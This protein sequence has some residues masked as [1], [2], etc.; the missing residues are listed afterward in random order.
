[1]HTALDINK[2]I[3]K[4]LRGLVWKQVEKI[5]LPKRWEKRL[6]HSMMLKIYKGEYTLERYR[7]RYC[8]RPKMFECEQ[9]FRRFSESKTISELFEQCSK[10]CLILKAIVDQWTEKKIT[11]ESNLHQQINFQEKI[12]DNL[13]FFLQYAAN[14]PIYLFWHSK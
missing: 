12:T 9:N 2:L 8:N 5:S 1:M 4:H 13:N 7:R 6:T 14:K 10:F 11:S 3:K